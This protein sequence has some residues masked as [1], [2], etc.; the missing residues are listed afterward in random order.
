MPPTDRGTLDT[1][2]QAYV[3]GLGDGVRL[4]LDHI[5]GKLSTEV[6]QDAIYTGP[7]PPELTEYI[8]RLRE[9]MEATHA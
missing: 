3:G 4:V 5:E 9:R 7:I 1:P 8:A 2:R 6:L